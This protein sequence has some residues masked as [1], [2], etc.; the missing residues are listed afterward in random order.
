MGLGDLRGLLVP[1]A[2]LALVA[3]SFHRDLSTHIHPLVQVGQV[4]LGHPSL[5]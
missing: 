3:Q 4:N 1:V 2:Q 5:P